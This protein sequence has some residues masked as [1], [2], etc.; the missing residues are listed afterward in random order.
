MASGFLTKIAEYIWIK[1]RFLR[2]SVK[3][4]H[5]TT[6]N[7]CK[8]GKKVRRGVKPRRKDTLWFV[9]VL[10][11]TWYQYTKVTAVFS[12]TAENSAGPSRRHR[13]GM[14]RA[15]VLPPGARAEQ[16]EAWGAAKS[17]RKCGTGRPVCMADA[18]RVLRAARAAGRRLADASRARERSQ[19]PPV[20]PTGRCFLSILILTFL[21]GQHS[22]QIQ[23]KGIIHAVQ[24]AHGQHIV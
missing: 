6:R 16:S 3:I 2:L 20:T 10:F 7:H 5:K 18:A 14:A 9:F 22:A 19:R 8:N 1:Q 12:R 11:L 21:F 4:N 24:V 15:G 17:T 13:R 23:H